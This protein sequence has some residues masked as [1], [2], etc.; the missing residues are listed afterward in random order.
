MREA[1]EVEASL[2]PGNAVGTAP[3]AEQARKLEELGFDRAYTAETS[4]DGFFPSSS[5]PTK[6]SASS[7]VPASPSPSQG[8]RRTSA[9]ANRHSTPRWPSWG[10]TDRNR[11]EIM[12]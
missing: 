4:R 6:P 10:P 7:S 8:T 2:Y 12:R 9:S 11:K 3:I 5:R 1:L